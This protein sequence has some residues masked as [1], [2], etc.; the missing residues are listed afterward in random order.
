MYKVMKIKDLKNYGVPSCIIDIWKEHYSPCLL[1]LQE[2]GVRNYGILSCEGS[3]GRDRNMARPT[4]D[5]EFPIHTL[6][7][8]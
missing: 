5:E 2:E 4:L 1:P 6:S 8:V 3:D 7:I